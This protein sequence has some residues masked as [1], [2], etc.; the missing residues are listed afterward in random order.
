MSELVLVD[1]ASG[2]TG[3]YIACAH[4][5]PED[6]YKHVE[7]VTGGDHRT[8]ASNDS[9]PGDILVTQTLQ[10]LTS[11][12]HTQHPETH[13]SRLCWTQVVKHIFLDSVI[14]RLQSLALSKEHSTYSTV[15][16]KALW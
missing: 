5:Y 16:V 9:N 12:R 11:C 14:L 6:I 4:Y 13:S 2:H 7:I 15:E 10:A 1:T 8:G 3:A